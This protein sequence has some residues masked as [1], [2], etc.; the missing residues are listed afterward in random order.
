MTGHGYYISSVILSLKSLIADFIIV[1]FFLFFECFF[2][3]LFQLSKKSP[4]FGQATLPWPQNVNP[5]CFETSST[6]VYQIQFSFFFCL[7]YFFQL[8]RHLF[9]PFNLERLSNLILP[10][11]THRTAAYFVYVCLII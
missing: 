4:F 10:P 3:I 6:T 1:F 5:F 2:C 9:P 8:T 7:F 11:P